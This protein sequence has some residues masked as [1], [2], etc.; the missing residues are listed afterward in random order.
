MHPIK[1]SQRLYFL[2]II[3]SIF[4]FS[5]SPKVLG[6]QNAEAELIVIN[7][8]YQK[9]DS[10]EAYISKFRLALEE[11]M[12]QTIAFSHSDLNKAQPE[13]TMGNFMVDIQLAY[14]KRFDSEVSISVINYGGLRIP[15]LPAGPITIGNIYEMMP[16]D[17]QLVI[18]EIPGNILFKFA[19]HMASFGGWPISGLSYD[20]K[21]KKAVGVRVDGIPV[22]PT[23]TYK[24][25]V[26]DYIADGGDQSIILKSLKRN[27]LNVIIRDLLIEQL[28]LM[29]EDAMN[30]NF[31]IEQRVTHHE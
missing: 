31:L 25:A 23:K 7:Q 20:I 14:A 12:N 21:N 6:I 5:C 26:S 30:L 27:E 4:A 3:L 1:L 10:F 11:Q 28:R 9:V 19:D 24:M 13:G 29:N 17:N 15:F 22:N 16:F 8:D 2:P 18:V